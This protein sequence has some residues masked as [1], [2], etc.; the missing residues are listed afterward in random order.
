MRVMSIFVASNVTVLLLLI[1]Y[2]SDTRR[3]VHGLVASKDD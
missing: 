3:L 2:T 1:T